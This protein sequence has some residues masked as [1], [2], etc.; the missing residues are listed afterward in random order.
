[1]ALVYGFT[2]AE[3]D[4]W[5]GPSTLAFIAVGVALLAVFVAVQRRVAHPL[6][7]LRIVVDRTRAGAFLALAVNTAALLSVF[8]FLT[9]YLQQNLGLTP[10]QTGLAFLPSPIVTALGATQGATRLARRFG[11]RLVIPGGMAL[12]AV[13]MVLLAQLDAQ[14]SYLVGVVPGLV[15]MSFGLGCVTG[16]AM[17]TATAGVE[18]GDAGA[19][20]AAVNAVQQV[21]GSL[22]AALLSTLAVSATADALTGSADTPDLVAAASVHGYTL[23]FWVS[24]ALLAAGATVSAALLAAQRAAQAR[25]AAGTDTTV[26]AAPILH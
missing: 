10:V 25:P 24:G 26:P 8:L 17:G 18:P 7:P 9:Y 16:L 21:G 13:G 20:G 14:S 23:A 4:G 2:R 22:G 5:A 19:A 1:M 6:L 15:L 11:A 3:T 12:A